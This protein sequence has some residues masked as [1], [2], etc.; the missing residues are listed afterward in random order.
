MPLVL[1]PGYR[2]RVL[3]LLHAIFL[4]AL[5][6]FSAIIGLILKLVFGNVNSS[7]VLFPAFFLSLNETIASYEVSAQHD[8]THCGR[9]WCRICKRELRN[10]SEPVC[11]A[12]GVGI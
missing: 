5:A 7:I 3:I 9:S 4:I 12:C 2:L 10:L 6:L 8:L 11:P 1:Q